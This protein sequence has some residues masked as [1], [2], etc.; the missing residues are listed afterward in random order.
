MSYVPKC[1]PMVCVCCVL[2]WLILVSFQLP[3][4]FRV[5][6]LA[7][8]QSCPS[9]SEATLKNMGKSITSIPYQRWYRTQQNKAKTKPCTN[10]MS[11]TVTPIMW[12]GQSAKDGVLS[13]W[14]LIFANPRQQFYLFIEHCNLKPQ[15]VSL[16]FQ[17]KT[18]FT[19]FHKHAWNTTKDNTVMKIMKI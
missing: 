19:K 6:S 16:F 17:V 2:L 18:H 8:G 15:T 9:A 7:L 13:L 10:I 3:I 4:S 12:S 5:P 14:C 1:M 11:S